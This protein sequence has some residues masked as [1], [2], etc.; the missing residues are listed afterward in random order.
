MEMSNRKIDT[1]C[2]RKIWVSHLYEY[3]YII[4]WSFSIVTEHNIAFEELDITIFVYP[5]V[6]VPFCLTEED[7]IEVM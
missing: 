7:K 6:P 5:L 3:V 1:L 4:H 2:P